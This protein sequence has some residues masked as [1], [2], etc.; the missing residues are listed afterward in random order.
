M[1][2]KTS[3][4]KGG[5]KAQETT[6]D[7]DL[8]RLAGRFREIRKRLGYSSYETFAYENG[9]SRITYGKMETGQNVTYKS[10]LKF[11]KA[12]D[13]TLAEFFSEGFE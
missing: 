8:E 4:V 7:A 13:M 3:A 6:F 9:F 11:V 5:R 12:A 1:K 2:K 10:L